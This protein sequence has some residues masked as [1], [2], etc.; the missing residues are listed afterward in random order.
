MRDALTEGVLTA[1]LR[2]QLALLIAQENGCPYCL[3]AHTMRG[4]MMGFSDQE[5]ARTRNAQSADP[6]THAVLTIAREV[7]KTGGMS[8]TPR[9]RTR[10][11]RGSRMPNWPRSWR[12]S[13]STF[14]R[15]TSTTWRSP[16]WTSRLWTHPCPRSR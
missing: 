1:K 9:W 7:M 3:S 8:T 12:T 13:P 6:H 5:L 2:E 16:S 11:A 4:G 10:G 14:C 15:T